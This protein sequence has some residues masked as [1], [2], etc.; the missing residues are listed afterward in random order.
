[1]LDFRVCIPGSWSGTLRQGRRTHRQHGEHVG[2]GVVDVGVAVRQA[3]LGA[4]L[5]EQLQAG[6]A[7]LDRARRQAH[8]LLAQAH[9]RL[10]PAQTD[11]NP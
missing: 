11:R 1:M 6:H 3:L 2:E 5:A 4:V 7:P 9:A 8:L 10:C